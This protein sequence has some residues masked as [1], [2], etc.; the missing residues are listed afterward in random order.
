MEKDV[1]HGRGTG[2]DLRNRF[3]RQW[4]ATEWP[5]G[6]DEPVH[7]GRPET[8]VYY[9]TPKNI[10]NKVK[11]PDVGLMYSANPYQGCEHGCIYCY[12]RPTHEY[13]GWN[14][15]LDFERRIIVKKDAPKLLESFINSQ[16]WRAQPI[17]LSG[18]TDC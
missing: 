6:L 8:E 17:M 1:M 13:W 14:S 2:E 10:V 7:T 9:D 16:E 5:E 11:S 3:L 15:G 18:N 12:A 4:Y